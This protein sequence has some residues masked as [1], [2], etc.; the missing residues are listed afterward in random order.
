MLG[1]YCHGCC[2]LPEPH[3]RLGHRGRAALPTVEGRAWHLPARALQMWRRC[4]SE[5]AARAPAGD[6]WQDLELGSCPGH[7]C[8]LRH[9][10]SARKGAPECSAIWEAPPEDPLQIFCAPDRHPRG[11]LGRPVR[12]Q[13][14][15]HATARCPGWGRRLACGS[16]PAAR[17]GAWL[18]CL[19]GSFRCCRRSCCSTRAGRARGLWG[20]TNRPRRL[21]HC[22]ANGWGAPSYRPGAH[23]ARRRSGRALARAPAVMA[24]SEPGLLRL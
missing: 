23:A 24:R 1:S 17:W 21:P 7:Q 22:R 20:Q 15:H 14:A 18:G 8:S 19:H 16:H 6:F 9:R 3:V 5:A 10:R 2:A 13:Y 12:G 11:R 4:A